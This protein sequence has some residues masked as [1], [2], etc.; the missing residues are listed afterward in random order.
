MLSPRDCVLAYVCV[1]V[2]GASEE[3]KRR[4]QLWGVWAARS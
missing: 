3:A 4:A 1:G 2:L